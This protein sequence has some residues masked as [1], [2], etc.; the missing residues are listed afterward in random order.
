MT[1]SRTPRTI[2]GMKIKVKLGSREYTYENVT[3]I[4]STGTGRFHTHALGDE[5]FAATRLWIY[6]GEDI[7]DTFTPLNG[8]PLEVHVA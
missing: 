5:P 4:D 8:C 1:D 7:L 6:S 2:E 3:R